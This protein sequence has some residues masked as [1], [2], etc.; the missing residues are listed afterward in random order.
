MK[1]MKDGYDIIIIGSG[2]AG[3]SA[4]VYAGRYQMKTLVIGNEF[5]GETARAGEIKNYPGFKSIG[6]FELMKRMKEQAEESGAEFVDGLVLKIEK[7]AHCFNV[8][9]GENIYK[10]NTIILALGAK[11]RR[12]GLSNEAD[13]AQKG[14]HYC[15]TCEAPLYKDKIVA[16]VGGGDSSVKGVVFA[17][18]YAKKI[19]F[20]SREKEIKAEPANISELKKL[21][22]KVE[23]LLETEIEKLFGNGKLEKIVLSKPHGSADTLD[24]DGLFVEIGAEPNIELAQSLG[25]EL[26]AQKYIKVDNM[27]KTSV[28]GVFAAGDAVNFFGSFKQDITAAAMGVVAATSAYTD[29]KIHGE[30]CPYHG[31]PCLN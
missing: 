13:F 19:Y 27:M 30:I 11:R 9:T 17:A 8:C 20:I 5:G 22:G 29:H 18:E 3:L 24:V 7:L 25:V 10:A 31:R 6:G 15:F 4:A 1:A 16:V 21:G 28:D 23:I 12:L 2:A 26:D 14:V